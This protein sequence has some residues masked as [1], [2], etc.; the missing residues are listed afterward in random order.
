[1]I[2]N[3]HAEKS[4]TKNKILFKWMYKYLFKKKLTIISDSKYILSKNLLYMKDCLYPNFDHIL[5][6]HATVN[7][8][9]F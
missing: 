2:W 3:I 6:V 4:L 7:L 1:M 9:K 8:D 5:I